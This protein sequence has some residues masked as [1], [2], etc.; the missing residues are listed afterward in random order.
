[1]TVICAVELH[2]DVAP[3]ESAGGSERAHGCFRAAR[4]ASEH[5]HRRIAGD[6]RIRELDLEGCRGAEGE[7]VCRRLLDALHDLGMRMTQDRRTPAPDVVDVPA[8]VGTKYARTGSTGDEHGRA[9]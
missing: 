7:S 3:R 2:D 8:P 9:A 1:M 5:L 4:H 6:D